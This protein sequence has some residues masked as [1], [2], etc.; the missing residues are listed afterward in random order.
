MIL[1]VTLTLN[2]SPPVILSVAKNLVVLRVNSLK[3]KGLKALEI[4][5]SLCS[6]RMTKGVGSRND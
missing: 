3:G 5:R 4:L 6:L 1:S 2:P